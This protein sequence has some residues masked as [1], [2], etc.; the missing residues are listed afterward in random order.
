MAYT[1]QLNRARRSL[2]KLEQL[3]A[4]RPSTKVKIPSTEQDE[5]LDALYHFFQDCW[6]IKDWIKNDPDAPSMLKDAVRRIEIAKA[7][8]KDWVKSLMLCADVANGSKHFDNSAGKYPPRLG[9]KTQAE[10]MVKVQDSLQATMTDEPTVAFRYSIVE[11]S[12]FHD[13]LVV[14]RQGLS[15]WESIIARRLVDREAMS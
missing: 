6:H 3:S 2:K 1:E 5:Y 13:A 8:D 14:A 9:A 10:I 11:S 15:D 4:L 12:T 7:S